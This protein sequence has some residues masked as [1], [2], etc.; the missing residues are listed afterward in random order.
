VKK[1]IRNKTT[2]VAVAAIKQRTEQKSAMSEWRGEYPVTKSPG[3]RPINF[4]DAN[5][6]S[7][8]IKE[9]LAGKGQQ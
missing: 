4:P 3:F 7:A 6:F 5:V 8:F 9:K 1:D 2:E